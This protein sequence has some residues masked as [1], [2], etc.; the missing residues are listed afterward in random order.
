MAQHNQ[1]TDRL[2][3]YGR[4]N[5]FGSDDRIDST[6]IIPPGGGLDRSTDRA[7]SPW[8][9]AGLSATQSHDTRGEAFHGEPL[10]V[11]IDRSP[12]TLN[13]P[14]PGQECLSPPIP[15]QRLCSWR[16]VP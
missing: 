5:G 8:G 13:D 14:A 7:R 4:M 2:C 6:A 3:A 15:A 11:A 12:V 1:S 9:E 16:A 10:M